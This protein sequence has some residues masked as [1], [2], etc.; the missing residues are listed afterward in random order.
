MCLSMHLLTMMPRLLRCLRAACGGLKEKVAR[1]SC[2][3]IG[4]STSKLHSRLQRCYTYN[5]SYSTIPHPAT[6]N[7][8]GLTPVVRACCARAQIRSLQPLTRRFTTSNR[9]RNQG[10]GTGENR[11]QANDPTPRKETP[12]VSKTNELGVT[13]MGNRDGVL[14]ESTEAAEK[15]RQMQAPN[16]AGTWSR[17]QQPREIAM[18]GPRFEQTIMDLQVCGILRS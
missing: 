12:N 6:L 11:E 14:Q 15:Q 2:S 8:A 5:A 10:S 16:R 9:L 1:S 4:N 17:N 3:P 13:A 18:T 7:M